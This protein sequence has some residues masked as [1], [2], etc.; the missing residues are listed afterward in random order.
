MVHEHIRD[1]RDDNFEAS[2]RGKSLKNINLKDIPP[3]SR[4]IGAFSSNEFEIIHYDPLDWRDLP[5]VTESIPPFSFCTS[6]YGRMFSEDPE[7]TWEDR[8]KEQLKRLNEFWNKLEEGKSLVFFYVNHGNPL[9][10]EKSDRIIVGVGRI[11][12][13]GRQLY[14]GK[15]KGWEDE[16]PL[17]SRCITHNFPNEGVRLPYQEY[18]QRGFDPSKIICTVP[19]AARPYFS[20]V[21][22]HVSDDIAAGI[23]ERV[24]Q[25]VK[26]IIKEN[27]VPEPYGKTW[28]NRLD[29]LN[30]VLEEV[31]KN[32]GRFPGIGSVL[33]YL[34]FDE[35]II[36]QRF[37]L[38]KMEL[39]G[40]NIF[41]FV[42]S[43]LNRKRKCPKEH[44]LSFKKAIQKWDSLP[45][46]RKR[47]LQILCHFELS[48]AQIERV[49]N[50]TKRKEAG[51]EASEEEIMKNPY[52][53]CELDSGG[54]DKNREYSYPIDFET[55]DRGMIPL[56]KV[57]KIKGEIEPISLDDKRRIRALL[58]E[59]LKEAASE[60]D[61]CLPID[62]A[63]VRAERKLAE[64][65]K[66]SPD[67]DVILKNR[68]F[69][70]ERITFF[71]DEHPKVIALKTIRIME[72]EVRKQIEKMIT[73]EYA[74]CDRCFWQNL[75]ETELR[76]VKVLDEEVENKARQEKI[77]AL[78]VLWRFRFSILT[79]YAG[80]GKT[81][82]LK[83]F[84]K[85]L[86]EK[87]GKRPI[88][89]LAPTGKARVRL[90]EITQKEA[91]T[92]H[93]FLM[94]LG[95]IREDIFSL[96]E[97][98][99]MKKGASTIIIDEASMIP[100][101]LLATLFRAI[102]FNEVKRLILVGDP[103]QL[104]PI[105]CGRPFIDIIKWL[106]STKDKERHI[107][108]VTQRV[109]HEELESEALKLADAFLSEKTS[110]GDDEIFSKVAQGKVCRDLEVHFWNDE[111][112]LYSLLDKSLKENIGLNKSS[113]PDYEGFNKS[114]EKPDSW[115]ILSP[116]RLHAFGT[117]EINRIIQ[118]KYRKN[119]IEYYKKNKPKPF[120]EQEIVYSDKVIQIVNS[121]RK[122]KNGQDGYVANGEVGYVTNVIKKQTWP[123]RGKILKT[124]DRIEVK[125]STQ[126]DTTYFY[127]RSEVDENLELAYAITVHKSQGSDFDKV[128]IVLPQKAGTMSKE[129]LYTALTR[130]K[131]KVILLIE[132]DVAPLLTFRNPQYS[133]VFKR[134]TNLFELAVR[135]ETVGL[136]HPER[137][138][139]KTKTGVLVRSKSEVIIANILTDLGI[140]YEYEK[141]L[142]SKKDPRDFRLPDFTIKYE[143]EEFFWEHLGMLTDPEY[144]KEWEIKEKWYRENGYIDK[145]IVSK[146]NPDGGIDSKAI[147]KIAK[148]RILR[149]KPE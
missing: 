120:G 58:V 34:G 69:Y 40:K 149:I 89:L 130:F 122:Q 23:L 60:G 112:E 148:E 66:C 137:L 83:L 138:I 96:K 25:S 139:H 136:P 20:Y 77:E 94:S 50:P 51:I 145:L 44:E 42:F 27:K 16:Y 84:I 31:W 56:E 78:D 108:R 55:I 121:W 87:E 38:S 74:P 76:E 18:I 111:K 75:V 115:Q 26:T 70:E 53:L 91:Q 35:G 32:R 6:P 131:Q 2:H 3:C 107:A 124:P 113:D 21:A 101:D 135:P 57:S 80:T 63:V 98:G 114:I 11:S 68:D 54:L 102:D 132:K 1:S 99:G 105:G 142:Y 103:N 65:R 39:K 141:P 9:K 8:P 52:I 106:E 12:K 126:S 59:I 104:P 43:I 19:S 143:G 133:E 82:T 125:F 119:L 134:N 48:P 4:D 97:K 45:A 95:W 129:L 15:K 64:S 10:E 22:E 71:P 109:R 61:T 73:R 28:E 85:G 37:V 144:R 49:V 127:N 46:E 5:A 67:K 36:Y 14:F 13:I 7:K 47:L 147:E 86:E 93:Q 123:W 128:F 62:E 110:P 24:I 92:I 29:W 72:E 88:L 81:T 41:K 116:T 140:S 33:E 146:D 100:L 30:R 79:G 118:R 117:T 90:Q 17:W